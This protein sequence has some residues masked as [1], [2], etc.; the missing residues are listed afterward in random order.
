ME[1]ST[2]DWCGCFDCAARVASIVS[3][4][5]RREK[6]EQQMNRPGLVLRRG[7]G[8]ACAAIRLFGDALDGREAA[9]LFVLPLAFAFA[10]CGCGP[11]KMPNSLQAPET[12]PREFL[13]DDIQ[14]PAKARLR[15]EHCLILGEGDEWF[16][17]IAA[18][19]PLGPGEV[20]QHFRESMGQAG[21]RAVSLV[22]S[23]STILSLTKG[24]RA[25]VVEIEAGLL[26]G[27]EVRITVSP[28]V[29]TERGGGSS[30]K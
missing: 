25:A 28:Q 8:S 16:G 14:L 12:V 3:G 27:S 5:R 18:S 11:L 15:K 26:G 22:R 19:T 10:L 7:R 1:K 2:H 29:K 23:G 4:S 20:L 6:S 9:R 24:G 17:R 21:W 13:P 30:E